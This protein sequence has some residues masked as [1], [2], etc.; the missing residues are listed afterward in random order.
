MP[1]TTELLNYIA[2]PEVSFYKANFVTEA[3]INEYL[4]T[5]DIPNYYMLGEILYKCIRLNHLKP[6]TIIIN[7]IDKIPSENLVSSLQSIALRS[8]AMILNSLASIINNRHLNKQSPFDSDSDAENY[9]LKEEC[10]DSIRI[11]LFELPRVLQDDTEIQQAYS[12]LHKIVDQILTQVDRIDSCFLVSS[13][14]YFTNSK[15]NINAKKIMAHADKISAEDLESALESAQELGDNELADLLIA[16]REEGLH[17]PIDAH[18]TAAGHAV[19]A[20]GEEV[21]PAG[22]AAAAAGRDEL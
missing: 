20:D 14:V 4:S 12:D 2:K 13:L 15:D 8:S 10:L 11:N 6:A 1:S 19:V 17:A 7:Y 5:T 22:V 18:E 21:P 16:A 9:R 3:H